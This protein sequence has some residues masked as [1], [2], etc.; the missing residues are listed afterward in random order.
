MRYFLTIIARFKVPPPPCF[1][2]KTGSAADNG[3]TLNR[4]TL[5]E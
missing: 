4:N 5:A 2:L 1:P 3:N